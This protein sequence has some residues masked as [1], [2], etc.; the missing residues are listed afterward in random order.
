MFSHVCRCSGVRF[1]E[2]T[3]TTLVNIL[4]GRSNEEQ[5]VGDCYR[6]LRSWS[7]LFWSS[8]TYAASGTHYIMWLLTRISHLLN[9]FE[10]MNNKLIGARVL[11]CYVIG[12]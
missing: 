11:I 7:A 2:Q 6:R 10:A 5:L 1:M 9:V 4:S 8:A 3:R 12:S